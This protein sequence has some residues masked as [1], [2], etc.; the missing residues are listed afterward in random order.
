MVGRGHLGDRASRRNVDGLREDPAPESLD[1]ARVY[2]TEG[3]RILTITNDG[4]VGY[5]KVGG[6]GG[7]TLVPDLASALPDV[8]A[9]GLT[10]R[11]PLRGGIAYSTGE[12]IRPG[13]LPPRDRADAR[14][15]IRPGTY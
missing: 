3:W 11:F 6:P 8:S 13:G 1:P 5:R 14:S 2:D 15:C 9:D 4:L 12:P 10:Y 7:A